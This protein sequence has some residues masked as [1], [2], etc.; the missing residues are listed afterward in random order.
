MQSALAMLYPAQCVGC[1]EPVEDTHGLCG[2]C[3]AETPFVTGHVCDK[4]GCPLPGDSDGV[5]DLCDDCL[6]IARPWSRGRAALI[7]DG[8]GRRFV[9]GIKYYDRLDLVPAASGWMARA[10]RPFLT[11]DLLVV[12][13]PAHWTRVFK[14]RYNQAAELARGVARQAGLDVAPTA[15]LR[16]TRTPKQDRKTREERFANLAGKIVP[17]PKH[18]AALKGRRILLVDD[19]LTSG[20]T[21]A[22]AAEACHAAGACDVFVLT[23]ARAVKD[24]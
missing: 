24:A 9:M 3:W 17:H 15:L 20:A 22:A 14:R 19:V 10:A 4:C 7:Y 2:K 16:P 23:L 8:Q 21:L 11:P 6:T 5:A 12:P 18:G 13:V 1:G